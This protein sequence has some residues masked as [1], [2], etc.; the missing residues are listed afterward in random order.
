MCELIPKYWEERGGINVYLDKRRDHPECP[1]VAVCSKECAIAR[2]IVQLVQEEK[3]ER[4]KILDECVLGLVKGETPESP[5][6]RSK[7]IEWEDEV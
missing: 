4:D 6:L 1:K 3:R 2:Q 5:V 7:Y